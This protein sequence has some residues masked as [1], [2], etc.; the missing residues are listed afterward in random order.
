LRVFLGILASDAV[1]V[2]LDPGEPPAAQAAV[3]TA[4]G[5]VGLWQGGRLEPVAGGGRRERGG[6][7]L[8]K[9]TSGTTGT[10]RALPFT[11]AQMAA[12]GEQIRTTMDVRPDDVILGCIP[13]GHSYG[14]GNVVLPLLMQGTAVVSGVMVLPQTMAAGVAQWR[15]TVFPA[16]PG[17]LRV[18]AEADVPPESL[19]SLRTVISAGAPLAPEIARAFHAKFGR[20]IHSFYGSSETGGIA[21]DRTGDAALTGRSVGRAMDGVTI[22]FGRGGRFHVCSAAVTGRGS[23]RPADRAELNE[24]GELVLLG[25]AGRMVKIAGRR[26][27]PSEIEGALRQLPGVH[28]A[29]VELNRERADTLAA[30]VATAVGPGELRAQLQGRIAG[31]KIPKKLVTLASFPLTARGKPD[32]AKVRSLLY[33]PG[34]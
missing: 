16:V 7:R 4:V 19:A 9:V 17:L 8:L 30:A 28:D 29:Y 5:A 27:D 21:Y 22:E 31:W 18:L 32:L 1:S 33:R 26:L 25:R 11:D 2:A 24:L 6:V 34:G 15:P 10:P 20:K 12:D 3:A 23:F 13:F 14:L